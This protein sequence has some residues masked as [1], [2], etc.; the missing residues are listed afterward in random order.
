M[1]GGAEQQ[2]YLLSLL[3]DSPPPTHTKHTPQPQTN[4]SNWIIVY[5]TKLYF[6]LK[7]KPSDKKL[8]SNIFTYR[9]NE[10]MKQI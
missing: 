3:Q 5:E 8:V 6:N 2:H 9:F 10:I 1:A 4:T 7:D